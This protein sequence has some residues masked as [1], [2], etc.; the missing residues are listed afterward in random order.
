[1]DG[2]MRD[3]FMLASYTFG[4]LIHGENIGGIVIAPRIT[5]AVEGKCIRCGLVWLEKRGGE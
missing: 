3:R 1:M 2:D 5:P 4:S